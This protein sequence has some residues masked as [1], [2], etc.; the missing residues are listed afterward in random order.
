M[1]IDH[2]NS[3]DTRHTSY[4]LGSWD[5]HSATVQLDSKSLNLHVTDLAID[6]YG[7]P[8]A[9]ERTYCSMSTTSNEYAYGWRF[10]FE[11]SLTFLTSQQQVVYT[12]DDCHHCLYRTKQ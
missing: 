7:P 3:Q 1:V 4:D 12:D 5:G 2:A 11:R 10:S 6:S 9:L 8:A